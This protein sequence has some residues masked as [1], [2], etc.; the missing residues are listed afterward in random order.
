MFRFE[1]T[2]FA[3]IIFN[4]GGVAT[5]APHQPIKPKTHLHPADRSS[6]RRKDVAHEGG[7]DPICLICDQQ[8]P[9]ARQIPD[10]SKIKVREV[11]QPA[12]RHHA[13]CLAGAG[14]K[15]TA[16]NQQDPITLPG[17][18][19]IEARTVD[20]PAQHKDV[21]VQCCLQMPNAHLPVHVDPAL[22][23]RLA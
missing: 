22:P 4:T 5:S 7:L 6:A 9:F 15:V 13:R 1:Q 14:G 2:P 8:V 10:R 3:E 11:E 23:P 21:D 12:P 16:I 18:L 19:V 20:T 17:Q